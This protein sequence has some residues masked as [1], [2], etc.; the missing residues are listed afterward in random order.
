MEDRHVPDCSHV[1][2]TLLKG[3]MNVN[4]IIKQ[5]G[6]YK[7]NVRKEI[8]T[9]HEAEFIEE[10][11]A[12]KYEQGKEKK[13]RLTKLGSEIANLKYYADIFQKSFVTF[14][15]K[16][17][18][19]ADLTKKDPAAVTR[20]L[21]ENKW[22]DN[23]IKN[24]QEWALSAEELLGYTL[25]LF[26]DA[27]MV[28]YSSIMSRFK[29]NKLAKSILVKIVIDALTNYLLSRPSRK[30][31]NCGAINVD[32]SHILDEFNPGV[33]DLIGDF[34]LTNKFV[35]SEIKHILQSLVLMMNPPQKYLEKMKQ[36]EVD[37]IKQMP[38]EPNIYLSKERVLFYEEILK[39]VPQKSAGSKG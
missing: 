12:K 21:K 22:T 8:S 34:D 4:Q 15:N 14:Q 30:C 31:T 33:F 16:V 37:I 25:R 27:L 9:L 28:K 29:L 6:L 11:D 32:E 24:Y 3:E 38:D 13:K 36:L 18:K 17:S 5:T 23:E 19:T 1:L 2:I 26:T 10:K 35:E 20:I 39:S 7:D